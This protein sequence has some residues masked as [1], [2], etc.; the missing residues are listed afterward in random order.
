MPIEIDFDECTGCGKCEDVC[1]VESI[2]VDETALVDDDE[3]I[4]CGA[5]AEECP[6]GCISIRKAS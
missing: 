1:P 6:V 4:E 5:C 3:C 2:A